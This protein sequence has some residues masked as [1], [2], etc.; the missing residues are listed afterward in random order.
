MKN[1]VLIA[2]FSCSMVTAQ[3][4]ISSSV[5]NMSPVIIRCSPSIPV[6]T[7]LVV[8]DGV[9]VTYEKL[10][11][12]N[13]ECIS[14]IKVVKDYEAIGCYGTMAKNGV[15]L[16]TTTGIT[17]AKCSKTNYPFKVHTFHD[18]FEKWNMQVDIE[19]TLLKV[20]GLQLQD[21]DTYYGLTSINMRGDDNTIVIVDGVRQDASILNNLNPNDIQSIK[22][23][24]SAAATNYFTSYFR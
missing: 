12:I 10:S 6:N 13:P 23:A 16:I 7:P 17:D 3:D 21:A 1:L 22:I 8:I 19:N 24:P 14:S 4:S 11:Q 20:S 9:P 2:L 15:I 5:R 18:F